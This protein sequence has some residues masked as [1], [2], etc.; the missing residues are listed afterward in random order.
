MT[1]FDM[2][3]DTLSWLINIFSMTIFHIL[4]SVLGEGLTPN[5]N[6]IFL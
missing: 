5:Q 4:L 6:T 3:S 2:V 1:Y